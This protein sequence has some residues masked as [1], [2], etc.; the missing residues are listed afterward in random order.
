M[1]PG[2]GALRQAGGDRRD[3][4][5]GRQE[6]ALPV[7]RNGSRP[8]LL[9]GRWNVVP[10][11]GIDD[12]ARPAVGLQPVGWGAGARPVGSHG[13]DSRWPWFRHSNVTGSALLVVDA[14]HSGRS[15]APMS[16][17]ARPAA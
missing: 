17:S 2:V 10:G 16:W 6:L 8:A 9:A 12:P 15:L 4:R 11:S 13:P 7:Q 14:R 5:A 3:D 1:L